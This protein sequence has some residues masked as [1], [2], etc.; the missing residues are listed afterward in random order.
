MMHVKYLIKL[1]YKG[2]YSYNFI[3]FVHSVSSLCVV[4]L[5]FVK[6]SQTASELTRFTEQHKEKM[7]I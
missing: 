5:D 3:L 1:L 7:Y 6:I 4:A 2:K